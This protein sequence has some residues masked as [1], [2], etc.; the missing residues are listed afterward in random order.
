M[1]KV[2]LGFC[3]EYLCFDKWVNNEVETA[4]LVYDVTTIVPKATHNVYENV[5][6]VTVNEDYNY[7]LI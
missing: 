3:Y 5:V 6:L 4:P 2:R 7:R 1:S